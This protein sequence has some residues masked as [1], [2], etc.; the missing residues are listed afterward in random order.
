MKT[1]LSRRSV[2]AGG[3][4]ALIGTTMTG[5]TKAETSRQK[6]DEAK[7]SAWKLADVELMK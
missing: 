2:I 5:G 4:L 1:N 3:A 6:P 7:T